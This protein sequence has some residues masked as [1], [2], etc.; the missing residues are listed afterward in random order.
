MGYKDMYRVYLEEVPDDIRKC[1]ESGK[2][3]IFGYTSDMDVI[4]KWDV[5]VFNNILKEYLKEEPSFRE[6]E[7]IDSMEDFARIVSWYAIRGYGAEVDITSNDVC[8]YLEKNFNVS[9]SLGGTCAQGAAAMNAVGFP[10]IAHL[11][12]KSK[13]VCRLINSSDFYLINENGPIAITDIKSGDMPIKHFILQYSKGD[14]IVAGG[15]EYTVPNSN[16][17]I[18][19]YDK[20]H[21]YVPIERVFLDY[22]EKNASKIYSYNISGFNGIIDLDIL[23]ERLSQLCEHYQIVK[24]EN[25]ECIL[26]LESAHYLNSQS[27]LTLFEKLSRH[28]DILGMNEEELINLAGQLEYTV[29]ENELSSVLNG[30]EL[31][32]NRYGLKGIVMHTKD[33]SMYYGKEIPGINIEK[34]LTLGN[35]MSGTRARTGRYGSYKDCEETLSLAL[36]PTGLRFAEELSKMSLNRC[37]HLVPSRYMEH[38]NCTI[39]LGDTFVAGMQICFTK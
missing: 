21:K 38:P 2:W 19:D 3:H 13:E 1:K 11:T 26:Y 39:G 16:R 23:N 7:T 4:V 18:I 24:R 37:V 27:K 22:C 17:I 34:G 20:V 12:D 9:F 10:V 8:E 33:Y 5:G 29:N 31:V 35:L 6:G 15:K 30:L 28:I 36:S 25:P 14:V 32:I